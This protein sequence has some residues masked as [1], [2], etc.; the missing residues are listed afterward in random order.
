MFFFCNSGCVISINLVITLIVFYDVLIFLFTWKPVTEV[1]TELI[2]KAASCW[3]CENIICSTHSHSAYIRIVGF[4]YYWYIQ[5]F[6]LLFYINGTISAKHN[7]KTLFFFLLQLTT[8]IIS[9][10]KLLLKH[11][12]TD[13]KFMS[14][15]L[16]LWQFWSTVMNWQGKVVVQNWPPWKTKKTELC[17]PI[18]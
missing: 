1:L 14:D 6:F 7:H 10:I 9:Y 17:C 18:I 5:S 13:R 8:L 12:E 3:L 15:P 4:I 11:Q 16:D 2:A